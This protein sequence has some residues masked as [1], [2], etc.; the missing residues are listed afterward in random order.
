MTMPDLKMSE[1]EARECV[2]NWE[3]QQGSNFPKHYYE[4]KSFLAGI[5]AERERVRPLI[6]EIELSLEDDC[7]ACFTSDTEDGPIKHEPDCELMA[8]LKSYQHHGGGEK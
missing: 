8:A 1:T 6:Q 3:R 5:E 2:A 7:P 4:A